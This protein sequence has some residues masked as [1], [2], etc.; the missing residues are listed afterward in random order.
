M[1]WDDIRAF[2]A[3]ARTGQIARAAPVL[4]V[5]ATTISRRL[6]RL[7]KALGQNLF[8]Q[9]RDGQRLAAA[10]ERLL[11][12]A[13]EMDR[14]FAALDA[15]G[16]HS[17]DG[18]VRLSTAEGF[19]TWFIAPRLRGFAESRPGITLDLVATS[20]FLSPSK[21]ET[22]IAVTLTRPR[23][24]PV[25]TRKLADYALGVYASPALLAAAPPI[26]RA[27]DLGAHPLIGYVPDFIY[28]PEL[29]YLDEI[30]PGLSPRFRSTSI[31]AQVQMTVAGAGLAILPCFVGDAAGGMIRILPEIDIRR[32]FWLVTHQDTRNLPRIR[33]VADWLAEIAAA[34][35]GVLLGQE[36]AESAPPF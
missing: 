20:G 12:R 24:G 34:E 31:N 29:N 13:E 30:A 11:L 14:A 19:G 10:G 9:H 36:A 3:V 21:R 18:L 4:G 8:E 16:P 35:R 17:L 33:I 22:D 28:A 7:E 15:A 1:N 25:V 27:A 32:S 26:T 23:R 2:L 5:D 6:R